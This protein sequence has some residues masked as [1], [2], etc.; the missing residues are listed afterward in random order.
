MDDA[1]G[2]GDVEGIGNLNAEIEDL[3]QRK[4]LAVDVL[5]ESFAIDELHG[6][7]GPMKLLANVVDG[8]D[9]GMI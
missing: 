6:D 4:R 1:F 7:E 5:A 9:A 2:V 8:A 3:F